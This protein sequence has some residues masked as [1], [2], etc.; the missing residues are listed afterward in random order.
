[1]ARYR[2]ADLIL[3]SAFAIP[4][5][6]RAAGFPSIDL[7]IGPLE[8]GAPRTWRHAWTV[9]GGRTWMR[10]A[11]TRDGHVI[12]F[13]GYAEFAVTPRTIVCAPRRGL[14]L[15]TLRHLL[16]DQV[17]PAIIASP[18]RLVLHASAV[19]VDGGAVGFLG[20]AGAGKSTLAAAMARRGARVV[21]D[22]ALLIEVGPEG[23]RAIPSYPGLR[24]W[25]E[26]RVLLGSWGGPTQRV[27][28]Y[29]RK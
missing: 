11:P 5:L 12:Q 15:A 6:P 16:L 4:E 1:M 3:A 19:T 10:V 20:R 7:S 22:D 18:R 28:H 14:P 29:T 17:L 23:P 25:P 26:A 2:F 21:T 24:L 9:P 8:S 27:A 13:P